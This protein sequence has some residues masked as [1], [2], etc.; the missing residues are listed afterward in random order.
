ML[1][2]RLCC[3]YTGA[4]YGCMQNRALEK[5]NVDKYAIFLTDSPV[6]RNGPFRVEKGTE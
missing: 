3:T 2:F 1:S 6:G 4:G 5:A